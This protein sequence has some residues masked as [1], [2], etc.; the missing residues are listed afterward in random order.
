MKIFYLILFIICSLRTNA[1]VSVSLSKLNN[2]SWKVIGSSDNNSIYTFSNNHIK[3]YRSSE[4][5]KKLLFTYKYYLT[6]TIPT[7]YDSRKIGNSTGCYIVKYNPKMDEYIYYI[8]KS[9]DLSTGT[10]VLLPRSP[11]VLIGGIASEIHY[12]LMK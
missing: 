9:F 10:M 4:S 6:K 12:K 2:T 5:G 3:W 8:I 11:E 7:K 1:Q